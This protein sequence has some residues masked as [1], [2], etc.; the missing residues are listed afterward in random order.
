MFLPA[1]CATQPRV[2]DY[3]PPFPHLRPAFDE[4]HCE[5]SEEEG[6]TMTNDVEQVRHALAK[7]VADRRVDHGVV[8]ELAEQIARIGHPL[9]GIDVCAL[10]ICLD[11]FVDTKKWW[12]ILPELVRVENSKLGRVEVFP[13]GIV[14]PDLFHIRVMH[15]VDGIPRH[16]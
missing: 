13:Y 15:D 4:R 16:R 5:S 10:G 1:I 12:D 14:N 2:L 11:Y 6:V 9:R 7:A 8:D 3:K